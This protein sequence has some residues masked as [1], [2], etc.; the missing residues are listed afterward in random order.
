MK[1][2]SLVLF[3][4][5]LPTEIPKAQP[6][7]EFEAGYALN[8]ETAVDRSS[9]LVMAAYER[10][11]ASPIALT[12]WVTPLRARLHGLRAVWLRC[13]SLRAPARCVVAP[14]QAMRKPHTRARS[15]AVSRLNWPNN[16]ADT[17]A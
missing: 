17:A 15:T 14:C 7:R 5:I 16:M 2:R 6:R 8:L 1:R 9:A 13:S 3:T 11:S 4:G 10:V 12:H